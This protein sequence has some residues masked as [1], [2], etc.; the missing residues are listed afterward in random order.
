MILLLAGY[1]VSAVM[2]LVFALPLSID[3]R[4]FLLASIPV[5]L[6]GGYVTFFLALYCYISDTTATD[7]RAVR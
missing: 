7:D 4:F 1:T 2:W 6:G 3:P 5:S